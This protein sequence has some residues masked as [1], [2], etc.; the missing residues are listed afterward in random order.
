MTGIDYGCG[1]TNID[2]ETSIRYGVISSHALASHA[3][4]TITND[5]TD[6]DYLDAIDSLTDELSRAIKSVLE[7]YATNYDEKGLATAI[8]EN[9]E[10]DLESTGD[11]TRY[12]YESNGLAFNVCSD[13]DI[14]VTKSPFYTLS[15]FCSPCAP[16]AGYLGSDGDVKTYCLP[17][18]WFDSGGPMPYKCFKVA[19]GTEAAE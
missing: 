7:N 19:D 18:E 9:L 5:G 16:G 17:P 14:F 6:L 12:S 3:W 2:T 13:G 8:V 1:R 11:C 4:D 10:F 15:A